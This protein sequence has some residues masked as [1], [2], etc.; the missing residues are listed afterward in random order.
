M[1]QL[2][3]VLDYRIRLIRVK[4]FPYLEWKECDS[5]E[6]EKC[7]DTMT[8]YVQLSSKTDM[9]EGKRA[10]NKIVVV[11]VQAKELIELELYTQSPN[12]E[13]EL[14]EGKT[15]TDFCDKGEKN[16]YTMTSH[17][18]QETVITINVLEGNPTV[19]AWTNYQQKPFVK[20]KKDSSIIH[21][22]IPPHK[23]RNE[24]SPPANMFMNRFDSFGLNS[25]LE[26]I[27]LEIS[28]NDTNAYYTVSYTSGQRGLELEDG[29]IT[30]TLIESNRSV[31]FFYDNSHRE[32]SLVATISFP[33]V[34]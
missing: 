34:G 19:K 17:K 7:I 23:D 3:P 28:D 6:L 24:T 1:F 30:S 33:T 12:G 5:V 21:I 15:I 25:I 27:H 16:K 26:T 18:Q 9:I 31:T 11:K 8:N 4:G 10:T 20:T 2:V 29:L 22:A 13:L 32:M 14:T